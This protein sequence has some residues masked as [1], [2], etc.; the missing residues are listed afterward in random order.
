MMTMVDRIFRRNHS[1]PTGVDGGSL[2]C[3]QPSS[4]VPAIWR[5]M[6]GRCP[7]CACT[8][9]FKRFLKPVSRCVACGEDWTARSSDDF[10]PYVVILMLGHVI[11]PG[12]ISLETMAHPPLWVHLVIWLPLVAILAAVFIQPAKGGV[13]ALQ[14]WVAHGA[15][16]TAAARDQEEASTPSPAASSSEL[17]G[18]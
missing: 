8:R 9:L 13:M 17:N 7:R 14:W 1:N 10:P 11:A 15:H 2:D 4:L 3:L 6:R 12:M 16:A 18:C 5:G